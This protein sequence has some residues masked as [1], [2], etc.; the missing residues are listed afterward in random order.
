MDIKTSSMSSWVDKVFSIA[1]LTPRKDVHYLVEEHRHQQR[2]VIWWNS[3]CTKLVEALC[4]PSFCPDK[5]T[6]G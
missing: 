4:R 2:W 1:L 6:N 5:T 3:L